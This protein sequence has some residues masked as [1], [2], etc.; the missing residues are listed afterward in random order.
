M[1]GIQTKDKMFRR[2]IL[3][4]QEVGI[5]RTIQTSSIVKSIIF[6]WKP[7]KIIFMLPQVVDLLL[8]IERFK[9]I[10]WKIVI[11]AQDLSMEGMLIQIR[12]RKTFL[13]H[14]LQRLLL[15]K[16]EVKVNLALF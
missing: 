5:P 16:V 15:A 12:T 11:E 10:R 3:Q 7:G 9:E 8:G 14:Q 2:S 4:S 6:L 13:L 1:L